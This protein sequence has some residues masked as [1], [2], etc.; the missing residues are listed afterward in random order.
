[1]QAILRVRHWLAHLFGL[2]GVRIESA[3]EHG[4]LKVH[5]VTGQTYYDRDVEMYVSHL[6]CTECGERK[7]YVTKPLWR[8]I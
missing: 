7:H 4:G 8:T 5:Y 3:I 1:M 6:V 2:N